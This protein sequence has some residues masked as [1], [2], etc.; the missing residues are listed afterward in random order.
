MAIQPTR[1]A[2]TQYD[3]SPTA[4][5]FRSSDT[6]VIISTGEIRLFNCRGFA[7]GLGLMMTLSG[8]RGRQGYTIAADWRR[9]YR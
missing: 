6:R 7:A 8:L 5:Q 9:G 2:T 3:R 4:I 1:Q